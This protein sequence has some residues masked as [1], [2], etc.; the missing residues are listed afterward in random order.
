MNETI[1]KIDIQN[2][3]DTLLEEAESFDKRITDRIKSGF[4]PDLRRSVKC[5][6][7]YKS[8]WREPYYIQLYLGKIMEILL[9]LLKTH[10][11]IGLHILDVGCGAG[12][13]SLELARNGY[14]VTAID[15]SESCIKTARETLADNPY[16]DGFGSLKYEV[17]PFHEVKGIYD[18]ILFCGS[19]HHMTNIQEVINKAYE[20]L[21]PEGFLLCYEPCH[22]KYRKQDAAQVALIRGILS[23]TNFW[24]DSQEISPL[25]RSEDTLEQYIDDIHTEYILERDKD[26]PGGQSP[27]DLSVDGEDILHALKSGFTEIEVRPGFSFIYRLLGGMRGP[28]KIIH[29]LARLFAL[30]DQ[31]AVQKGF[32]NANAFYYLGK[33][34]NKEVCDL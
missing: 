22:E 2:Q 7:F 11:G 6:F 13:M 9:E 34:R 3:N 33:R 20:M 17:M 23:L 15:I 5:N 8:F 30:Y 10:C 25:L 4:I 14:H 32:L 16:K 18:G 19:L 12:Y 31:L 29:D 24:Y 28:E 27:H 1:N 26:E 21:P